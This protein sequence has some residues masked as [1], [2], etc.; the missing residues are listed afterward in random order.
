MARTVKAL[1]PEPWDAWAD[2]VVLHVPHYLSFDGDE[3]GGGR[4]RKVRDIALLI[5]DGWGRDVL[6]AQKA[7]ADWKRYDANGIPVVGLRTPLSAKGDPAFGFRTR[8]L[9][10]PRDAIAYLGGEDAWP[11][12]VKNSK[13][14]HVGVWWDGPFRAYR[15]RLTAL[16]TESL[17]RAAR[18][19][20]CVDTNV[21]NWL[22]ARGRGNQAA[23]NAA[24]YVPNYVDLHRIADRSEVAPSG[25]LR[26]LF[27]R[28]FEEKRGP[29]L[30]L[31]AV[32]ELH[33]RGLDIRITMSTPPGQVGTSAIR[34]SAEKR[35]ISDAVDTVVSDMDSVLSLYT[36][37]DVV[38]VP[39]LWSEGTSYSC[40]EALAAGVPVV[41][42]T[43]GGLPNLVMPDFNGYV[44]PPQAQAFA[45]AIA[46][47]RDAATWSRLH[48]NAASMRHALS[49]E[50]WDGQ[51]LDWLRS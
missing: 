43:V 22:R 45:D 26:L 31:A 40:V 23:A 37:A 49:K 7:T 38:L 50:R 4:Q 46:R 29:E 33:R 35:G 47:L 27:A 3:T 11:Y 14:I 9:L 42:T 32:E 2:R 10:G 34:R 13:A 48:H 36:D 28:R 44:V 20:L 18:T 16:R 15:K 1:P 21:I 12:F 25:I 30:A 5:R 19:V 41:A 6:I 24:I 39:T 51:V 17:F 8:R